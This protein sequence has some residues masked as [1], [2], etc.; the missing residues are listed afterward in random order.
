PCTAWTVIDKNS[1]IDYL[2]DH[3]AKAGDGMNFKA[4][5]WNGASEE[6]EKTHTLGGL[7]TPSSCKNKWAKLKETYLVVVALQNAS[8]FSWSDEKGADVD[9][10]NESVWDV[11]VRQH[12]NVKPFRNKGWT[13]FYRVQSLMPST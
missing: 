13:H 10:S 8:G 6:F 4:V 11:Y 5:T 9:K 7:K 3:H 1:S 12:P 2:E